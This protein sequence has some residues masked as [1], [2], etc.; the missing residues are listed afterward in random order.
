MEAVLLVV[1]AVL[2]VLAT[3]LI[4][5]PWLN[6][7]TKVLVATVVSILGAGV[8]VFLTGDFE[9]GDFTATALQVFAGSQLIYQFILD[10]TPLD[11]RLESVGAGK[12]NES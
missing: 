1:V 4:K 10:N 11:D 2:V 3:S 12:Y 9:A 7:K 8:H 6:K 5:T